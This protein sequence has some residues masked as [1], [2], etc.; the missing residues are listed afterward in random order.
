MLNRPVGRREVMLYVSY[1]RN[2]QMA[3]SEMSGGY[4]TVPGQVPGCKK[5][6][7]A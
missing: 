1:R 3:F 4:V 5:D 2:R 7:V 6:V